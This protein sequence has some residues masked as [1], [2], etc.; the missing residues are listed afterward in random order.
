MDYELQKIEEL[1]R[2]SEALSNS[3]SRFMYDSDAIPVAM[4]F[5]YANLFNQAKEEL[6]NDFSLS[7]LDPESIRKVF[8]LRTALDVMRA[9]LDAYIPEKPLK[10]SVIDLV[11]IQ[12]AP[13]N[14]YDTISEAQNCYKREY[15]RA[16]CT[17]CGAVWDR[18][19][20]NSSARQG[21]ITQ[22]KRRE[23]FCKKYK[24]EG[25]RKLIDQLHDWR[26]ASAHLDSTEFTEDKAVINLKAIKIALEAAYKD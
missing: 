7:C 8:E 19:L 11:G 23:S 15:Y 16:C 14:Y 3:L 4:E 26:G 17:L 21:G 6:G 25:E 10:D 24:L 5:A 22:E 13:K 20:E 12:N 9:G 1:I 2:K 18:L